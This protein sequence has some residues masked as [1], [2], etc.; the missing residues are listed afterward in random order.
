M[1]ELIILLFV[2]CFIIGILKTI[3]DALKNLILGILGVAII[4]AAVVFLGPIALGA[5]PV[6]L[7]ILAALFLLGCIMSIWTRLKYGPQLRKLDQSGIVKLTNSPEDWEEADRLGLVK[8]TGSGYVV[9]NRFCKNVT[10]KADRKRVVTM[11]TFGECC[12]RVAPAFQPNCAAPL[13]EYM[14]D[15]GILVPLRNYKGQPQYLSQGIVKKCERLLEAEGAATESEFSTICKS[16]HIC[17]GFRVE[18]E[19]IAA[20][21]LKHLEGQGAV[22][23]VRL[24]DLNEDLFVSNT[25]KSDSKMVRREI[26]MD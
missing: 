23:K 12:Q 3:W 6:I 17:F 8:V 13:L 20:V 26:S 1:I 19:L 2:I 5:L 15:Q 21:V 18:P 25:V 4:I 9:S 16:A 22:H 10:K 24:T 14:V 7:V 11:D